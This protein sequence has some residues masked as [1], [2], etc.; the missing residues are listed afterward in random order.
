MS[1][2]SPRSVLPYGVTGRNEL[3]D[4][5]RQA[6]AYTIFAC[7]EWTWKLYFDNEIDCYKLMFITQ[8]VYGIDEYRQTFMYIFIMRKTRPFYWNIEERLGIHVIKIILW[9]ALCVG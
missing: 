9:R 7:L 2:Y 8:M 6:T 5:F 1:Q 4:W 3:I